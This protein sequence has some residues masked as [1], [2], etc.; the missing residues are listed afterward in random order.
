[1]TQLSP[2]L[3]QVLDIQMDAPPRLIDPRTNKAYVLL[4]AEQYDRIKALFEQDDD[5]NHTY[6]AQMESAMRA[7]W[8]DA[9][10]DD[11]DR[12]DELRR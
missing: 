5:L 12:Y 7:G 10:M 3:Q 8:G 1:M 6:A 4:A 9:T 11:Y 2:E